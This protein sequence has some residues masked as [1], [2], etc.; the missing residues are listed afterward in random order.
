MQTLALGNSYNAGMWKR[1]IGEYALKPCLCSMG[2][3]TVVVEKTMG[4]HI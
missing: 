2:N 4:M 3:N 1:K